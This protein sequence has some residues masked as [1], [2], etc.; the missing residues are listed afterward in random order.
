MKKTELFVETKNVKK[1]FFYGRVESGTITHFR[2]DGRDSW[3][4]ILYFGKMVVFRQEYAFYPATIF[5]QLMQQGIEIEVYEIQQ[6]SLE[7]L[8]E[9]LD[10][11]TKN[12]KS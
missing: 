3:T 6:L 10:Q 9:L 12:S 8:Q 7:C 11:N 1:V 4:L 2:K 5:Q